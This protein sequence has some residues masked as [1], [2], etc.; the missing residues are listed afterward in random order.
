MTIFKSYLAAANTYSLY[1]F[2]QGNLQ[3]GQIYFNN[4]IMPDKHIQVFKLLKHWIQKW[5]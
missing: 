2:M 5:R 4:P 1:G 3:S